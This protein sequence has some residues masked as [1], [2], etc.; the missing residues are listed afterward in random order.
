MGLEKGYSPLLPSRGHLAQYLPTQQEELP[1]RTMQDSF[2]STIIPLSTDITLQE[3]YST[4]LGQVRL[5]RLME[6]MDTFAG[7]SCFTFTYLSMHFVSYFLNMNFFTAWVAHNHIYNP[8]LPAD[9]PTPYVIVTVLV[10]QIDFTDVI[11]KVSFDAY[12]KIPKISLYVKL[13]FH[14]AR[15]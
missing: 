8:K 2:S 9:T 7:S 6:D 12:S 10:D 14:I 3:K 4:F 13:I 5:G 11:P 15:C 1:A